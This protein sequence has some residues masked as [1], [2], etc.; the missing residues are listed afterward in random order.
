MTLKELLGRVI[1]STRIEVFEEDPKDYRKMKKIGQAMSENMLLHGGK[2]LLD[3][4]V[5]FFSPHMDAKG[6]FL[7]IALES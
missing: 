2:S 1:Y 3:R 4:E 7:A 5:N 6:I